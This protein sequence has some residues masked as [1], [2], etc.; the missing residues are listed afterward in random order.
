MKLMIRTAYPK[1]PPMNLPGGS[2]PSTARP[3]D[4]RLALL[5]H[6]HYLTVP[7]SDSLFHDRYYGCATAGTTG[8]RGLPTSSTDTPT[9]YSHPQDS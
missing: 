1:E 5:T 6:K 9:G 2:G 4:I 3:V 8:Q 7:N